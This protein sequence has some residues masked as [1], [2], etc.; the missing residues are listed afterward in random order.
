MALIASVLNLGVAVGLL[1]VGRQHGSIV[2]E[3]DGLH[4]FTDVLTS[5][6]V[7]AGLLLVALTGREWLDPAVALIVSVRSLADRLATGSSIFQRVDGSR[8]A[9]I[10][11]SVNWAAKR[12][13]PHLK[14]GTA[15]HVLRE[16]GKR[17]HRSWTFICSCPAEPTWP[18]HT[19]WA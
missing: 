4:L 6:G 11:T 17:D 3:A 18:V 2:L 7:V 19:G 10:G 13:E 16:P 14:P 15:F 12:S 1:R 5:A 9:A 8:I